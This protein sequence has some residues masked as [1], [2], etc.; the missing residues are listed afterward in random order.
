MI[1][2]TNQDLDKTVLQINLIGWGAW[3]RGET[4]GSTAPTGYICPLA[5]LIDGRA[6]IAPTSSSD[7]SGWCYNK[8]SIDLYQKIDDIIA[9]MRKSY[10]LKTQLI[11]SLITRKYKYRF[12]PKRL[13]K[14]AN[15]SRWAKT[16]NKQVSYATLNE[17]IETGEQFIDDCLHKVTK[18]A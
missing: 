7:P 12:T 2:K 8:Y 13:R 15:E 4:L 10:D 6:R 18:R 9:Q 1:D 5:V 16:I 3:A 11:A 14:T 17:L